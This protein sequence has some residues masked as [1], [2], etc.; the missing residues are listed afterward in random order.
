[1]A[2]GILIAGTSS[3][4]GK[5]AIVTGLCRV[6]ANRGL[7]VAPFKAQNMSNNSMVCPDGAEIGRAQYLQCQ[8]ARVTPSSLVNPVLLKPGSDRTSHIIL[9]GKPHGKL[10]AGQYATGRQELAKAAFAAFEELS[11]SYDFI[12]A[13]GAGS[14]AE[15]NLRA[16]DYVNMGLARQFNL[17]VVIVGDI[18]RGGVLAS[19]YGT[20]A[21]LAEDDRRLLAGYIINKFRGDPQVLEPGLAEISA[22]TKLTNFGVLNWISGVWTD[23]EDALEV[24]RWPQRNR[25]YGLRVAVVRFP[26]ISNSTDVDA[27]A[28]E[29]GITVQVSQ[30]A[31]DVKN[32][33]LVVLPGTRATTS[34]LAWLRANGIADAIIARHKQQ[35]PILGICGGY[36]MLA[37]TIADT[38]EG[39]LCNVDG[40]GILPV[41]VT[42]SETK[43]TRQA[44]YDWQGHRVFGYEIH[45]GILSSPTSC[46]PF[47]DGVRVGNT[48]A[49]MLHGSLENDGFRRSLLTEVAQLTGNAWRPDLTAP[50]YGQLREQMIEALALAIE[51]N[52][53]VNRLLELM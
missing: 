15:I 10:V 30:S 20:W 9:N 19:I 25:N 36:E 37:E 11:E 17:P 16:G 47:L 18:D 12:I 2:D 8:A 35:Q 39:G 27:L 21:L 4:A 3:D 33:D 45:H 49:T 41:T 44:T 29:P 34:D 31:L 52:V 7:S 40:L 32:A 46:Q 26:R 50:S 42:F 22:R 38:V 53:D 28:A 48:F 24:A 13:E 43:I 51:E 1:M 14:P 6:L 23:G 5:S